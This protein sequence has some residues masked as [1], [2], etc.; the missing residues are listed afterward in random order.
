MIGQMVYVKWPYLTE[1]YLRLQDKPGTQW[2]CV[3]MVACSYLPCVSRYM[4]RRGIEVGQVELM[5][6]V[7]PLQEMRCAGGHFLE[8]VVCEWA[9]LEVEV[10]GDNGSP[11]YTHTFT[12]LVSDTLYTVSVV[13]INC[14]G[15]S[16]VTS[17]DNHGHG[18]RLFW[19]E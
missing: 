9:L 8:V 3:A 4:E 16:N 1:A 6:Y 17:N 18:H 14:A 15:S 7:K 12:G 10:R 11:V 2:P 13:A 19:P 5:L